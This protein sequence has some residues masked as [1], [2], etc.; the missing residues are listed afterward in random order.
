M[1][2]PYDDEFVADEAVDALMAAAQHGDLEAVR[3]ALESGT[4]VD[5]ED[6]NG[7]EALS[8]AALNNQAAVVQFL[9]ERGA[10]VNA[11]D[12]GYQTALF[13]ATQEGAHDAAIVLLDAGAEVDAPNRNGQ[14][15]LMIAA[16]QRNEA[17]MQLLIDRGADLNAQNSDGWTP[18]MD[19]VYQSKNHPLNVVVVRALLDAGAPVDTTNI[20]GQTALNLAAINGS[21]D[22]VHLLI[23]RGAD[24]NLPDED[25]RTPLMDAVIPSTDDFPKD[26][27]VRA[28]LEAGAHINAQDHKG[29]SALHIAAWAGDADMVRDLLDHGADTALVDRTGRTAEDMANASTKGILAAHRERPLLREA[30]GLTDDQ[31]P[32]QRHRTM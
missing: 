4:P 15:P 5:A 7:N 13:F 18:L 31:E 12:M 19:A 10:D 26:A 11:T 21:L 29:L 32:M 2:D 22:A 17:T 30:A 27:V 25:Q 16:W 1:I 9:I 28:L 14:T 23:E 6:V 8:H 24:V 3:A 20:R